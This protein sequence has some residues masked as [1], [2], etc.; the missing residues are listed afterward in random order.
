MVQPEAGQAAGSENPHVPHTHGEKNV[1][2]I[3]SD[4]TII[5]KFTSDRLHWPRFLQTYSHEGPT[6]MMNSLRPRQYGSRKLVNCTKIPELHT[7]AS[8]DAP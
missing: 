6:S 4:Q 2:F 3:R 1:R 5:G 7:K 8:P